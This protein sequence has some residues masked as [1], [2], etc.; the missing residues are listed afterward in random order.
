MLCGIKKQEILNSIIAGL[1]RVSL[2]IESGIPG[3]LWK[4]SGCSMIIRC[5]WVT[6]R[7]SLCCDGKWYIW[8]FVNCSCLFY[9]DT[10]E[11]CQWET[12][13][14]TCA[15]DEVIL[16]TA[17]RYGRMELGRCVSKDYGHIGQYCSGKLS[18]GGANPRW[19]GATYYLAGNCIQMKGIGLRGDTHP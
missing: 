6:V 9:V 15:K 1:F 10:P 8:H 17:A 19:G 14:T 5:L 7:T 16:M 3:V 13:N 2:T 11:Y 18:I 4:R 12:Y